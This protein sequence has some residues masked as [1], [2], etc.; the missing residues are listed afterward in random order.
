MG[1]FL[2]VLRVILREVDFLLLAAFFFFR[3]IG[4]LLLEVR[5]RYTPPIPF[6]VCSTRLSR[7][8]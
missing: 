2:G 7:S 3:A 4:I 6:A 5:A 1:I 8:G